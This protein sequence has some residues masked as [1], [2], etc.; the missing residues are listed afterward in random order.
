M[1]AEAL[2]ALAVRL[3][4]LFDKLA[5]MN[6]K[7]KAAGL[8]PVT[9]AEARAVLSASVADLDAKIHAELNKPPTP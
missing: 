6:L 5:D 8:A 1:T 7:R 9:E 4:P 2:V 3:W